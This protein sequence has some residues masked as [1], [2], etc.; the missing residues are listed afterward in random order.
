MAHWQSEDEM[1]AEHQHNINCEGEHYAD[2]MNAQ[3]HEEW[4][5]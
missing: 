1:E 5:S 3:A 2:M 4:E